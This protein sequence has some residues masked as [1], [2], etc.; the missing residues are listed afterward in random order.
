M[1]LKSTSEAL[2]SMRI[3]SSFMALMGSTSL[4]CKVRSTLEQKTEEE[5]CMILISH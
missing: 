3:R 2:Q 5:N 1:S 4:M